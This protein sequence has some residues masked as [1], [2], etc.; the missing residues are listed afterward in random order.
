MEIDT[1]INFFHVFSVHMKYMQQPDKP[2]SAAGGTTVPGLQLL[3]KPDEP[4][5]APVRIAGLNLFQECSEDSTLCES[6]HDINLFLFTLHSA[7]VRNRRAGA[8]RGA[9]GCRAEHVKSWWSRGCLC[10]WC[11]RKKKIICVSRAASSPQ[12]T[13][14]VV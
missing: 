5:S 13:Y 3:H 9:S 1:V 14:G 12:L 11:Y 8:A 7:A 6:K 4:P 2:I 10:S